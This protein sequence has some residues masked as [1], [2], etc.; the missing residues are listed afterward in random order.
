MGEDAIRAEPRSSG[1]LK[2][3][4]G[5][6]ACVV[7]VGGLGA[8]VLWYFLARW[9]PGDSA[10]D[11]LPPST[12]VAV[13]AHDIK[14]LLKHSL[15]DKGMQAILE[16][17]A[18]ALPSQAGPEQVDTKDLFEELTTLHR[19]FEP[20][21][22]LIAPNTILFGIG[23]ADEDDIFVIFKPPAWM[24]WFFGFSEKSGVGTHGD[25]HEQFHYSMLD[26][27]FIASE[28]EAM[29]REV[30]DNWKS[31]GKPLGAAFGGKDAFLACAMLKKGG[32][33]TGDAPPPA[34]DEASLGLM[35]GDPFAAAQP[36][37]AA[38][39]ARDAAARFAILPSAEGWFILAEAA[40]SL[41]GAGPLAASLE[42]LRTPDALPATPEGCDFSVAARIAPDV[43]DAW[44]SLLAERAAVEPSTA[45]PNKA[46]AW[47]WLNE[48][49]LANA[50]GDVAV[51]GMPP[52]PAA[53]APYPPLPVVSVGWTI[54]DGVPP[55]T[56][57]AVFSKSLTLWLDSLRSPG[58]APALQNLKNDIAYTVDGD[59]GVVELPAVAVNG[60][61]PAW[62]FPGDAGM[63]MG[64]LATDPAGIP[65]ATAQGASDPSRLE[66]PDVGQ[67]QI[68]ANWDCRE[69]FLDA[70][71][72]LLLDRL[73]TLPDSATETYDKD[74][75]ESALKT[76]KQAL[77]AF[78]RG[79]IRA[80][81]DAERRRAAAKIRIPPGRKVRFE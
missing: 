13:E 19:R 38:T 27:W 16:H 76:G 30:V 47:R 39:A 50:Q 80:E 32:G 77:S 4:C 61:R 66:P 78:P 62:R 72:A 44:R 42:K 55:Q 37:A 57:G 8:V 35:F 6:L 68:Q 45:H 34:E 11:R 71:L 46:L 25:K 74:D 67:V 1:C 17:A 5:C 43:R 54:R 23:G 33:L 60:A 14:T 59:S 58:G 52:V 53:G 9:N 41:D 12:V 24:G 64:W 48:G 18:G 22:T 81:Y 36:E 26:G 15:A 29:V 21:F 7:V 73:E 75:I 56:A 51:L 69:A 2:W 31:G 70:W 49:W 10:W 65:G 20:F 40:E 28:S 79:Q 3:T 63:P